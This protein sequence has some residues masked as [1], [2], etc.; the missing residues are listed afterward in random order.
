[1]IETF[2][3]SGLMKKKTK[4]KKKTTTGKQTKN[5]KINSNSVKMIVA[6]HPT[7]SG[8]CAIVFLKI[9]VKIV[10]VV[11]PTTSGKCPFFFVCKFPCNTAANKCITFSTCVLRCFHL[12]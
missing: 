4:K 6:V 10:M 12:C 8:K 7:T 2:G 9:I 5:M 1:M 11:H 3:C